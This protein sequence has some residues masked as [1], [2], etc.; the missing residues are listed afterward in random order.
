MKKCILVMHTLEY[1]RDLPGGLVKTQ[2]ARMHPTT[3]DAMGLGG[4]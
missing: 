1:A 2:I 3:S 4:A